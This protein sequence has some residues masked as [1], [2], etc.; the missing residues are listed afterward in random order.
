MASTLGILSYDM[1]DGES[2]TCEMYLDAT[3]PNVSVDPVKEMTCWDLKV[4][5][6]LKK[7]EPPTVEEVTLLRS[8]DPLNF[9]LP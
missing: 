4:S 7:V 5:P 6:T 2:G 8:L 9:H 3:F 1:P